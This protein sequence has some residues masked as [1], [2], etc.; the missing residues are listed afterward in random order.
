MVEAEF[1]DAFLTLCEKHI[2]QAKLLVKEPHLFKEEI[3]KLNELLENN[4]SSIYNEETTS[5]MTPL[6]KRKILNV[7]EEIKSLEEIA[8]S[9]GTWLD[10]FESFMENFS[11]K[12]N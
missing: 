5:I 7:I 6:Q 11:K 3:V 10:G 1:N 12:N 9:L 4:W 2:S 8:K